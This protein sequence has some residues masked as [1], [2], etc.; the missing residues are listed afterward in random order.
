[1]PS[2]LRLGALQ[3]SPPCKGMI[4]TS[5]LP[6]PEL[7]SSQN[8]PPTDR[9]HLRHHTEILDVTPPRPT[10]RIN[11]LRKASRRRVAVRNNPHT[12]AYLQVLPLTTTA[13]HRMLAGHNRTHCLKLL[14]PK[15]L[16]PLVC[17]WELITLVHAKAC[18]GPG[19]PTAS[20]LALSPNPW[21]S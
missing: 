20:H 9:T 10:M 6:E 2:N 19:N 1:M 11:W 12:H 5:T 13:P 17:D 7:P 3:L 15:I 18:D 8:T 16:R 14:L 21:D 4:F